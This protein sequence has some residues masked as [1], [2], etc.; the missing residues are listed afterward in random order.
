[1]RSPLRSLV[2]IF[3]LLSTVAAAWGQT[4]TDATFIS[5]PSPPPAVPGETSDTALFPDATRPPQWA[6]QVDIFRNLYRIRTDLYRSQRLERKDV[7]LLRALNIRT[8]INLRAF[9]TDEEI[10]AD[11]GIRRIDIPLLTWDIR[12]KHVIAVLGAIQQ[13]LPDGAVLIHCQHGADRTGLIS[14]MYRIVFENWSREE[15]LREL[16]EGGY[17]YHAVW[18][19]IPR[20]IREVDIEK[21]RAA[22]MARTSAPLNP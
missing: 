7:P 11:T 9:H 20:Y 13:S 12:D 18:K 14:A 2:F 21:I 5:P 4:D 1:M 3:S 6:Q 19:N 15:A 16:T 10:L 22:V 8:V 17:G